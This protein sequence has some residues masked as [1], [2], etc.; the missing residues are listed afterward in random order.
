LSGFDLSDVRVHYNSSQPAQLNALAY[1]QGGDIH[2]APGQEKHVP[3][4][5]WHVVQQRQ[6]C[7]QPTTSVNNVAVNDNAGLETEADVMGSKALQLKT[8][9]PFAAMWNMS[10]KTTGKNV[11][12][13]MPVA[14]FV[15]TG[16]V[17]VAVNSCT[18]TTKN[19]CWAA[20]GWCIH[21][22]YGGAHAT[23]SDFVKAQ[24]SPSGKGTYTKDFLTDVN[25][26]IGDKSKKNLLSGSDDT[27]SYSKSTISSELGKDQPIVANIGGVHYVVI[28]GKRKNDDM[29]QLRIMDPLN[30]GFSWQDTAGGDSY[31]INSVGGVNIS[32]LYYTKA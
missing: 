8:A 16:E 27:G 11:A 17:T 14:Q 20:A 4:E 24:A 18:Q 5:G 25:Q 29:Y 3:H 6:G 2:V 22:F 26:A 23:E 9:E 12:Q 30:G 10:G 19:H 15:I 7:V 32:V 31:T 28:C 21:S 13:Q 1:A